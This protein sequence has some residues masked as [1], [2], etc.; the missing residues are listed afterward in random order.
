VERR[1]FSIREAAGYG[2]RATFSNFGMFFLTALLFMFAG[3]IFWFLIT[4]LLRLPLNPKVFLAALQSEV[5]QG[6]TGQVVVKGLVQGFSTVAV[7]ALLRR[8][9]SYIFTTIL[10]LGFTQMAFDVNDKGTSRPT[11]L[12][13]GFRVAHRYLI[14]TFVAGLAVF[15]LIL[16]FVPAILAF[17]FM[18]SRGGFV[19]GAIFMGFFLM[20]LRIRFFFIPHFILDKN[21]GAMESVSKSYRSARGYFW[22][23]LAAQLLSAFMMITIIGIPA[24]EIMWVRI[25][26]KLAR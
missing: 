19:I 21:A 20:F 26:R 12:F 25:Y 11:R 10:G 6:E 8:F 17:S 7:L 14:A 16:L 5:G 2:F 4:L 1:T 13:S 22:K 23:L 24:A 3:T 9:F 15:G 18:I